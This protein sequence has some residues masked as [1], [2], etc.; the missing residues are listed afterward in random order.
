M[1]PGMTGSYRLGHRAKDGSFAP[2]TNVTCKIEKMAAT[3]SPLGVF[4]TIPVNCRADGKTPM[5]W[6]SFYAVKLG[7]MVRQES[8]SG[9]RDLIAIRPVTA[10]WPSAARAGLDWALT[11]ALD[12]QGSTAPVLWSSTAVAPRF[13]IRAYAALAPHDA[14]LPGGDATSSCRRFDLV[15]TGDAAHPY[16][17]IACRNAKGGWSLPGGGIAIATPA[18]G[19]EQKSASAL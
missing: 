13:E 12:T 16:P 17:G 9:N 5:Q 15:Q 18:N 14:G 8:A 7:Q 19:F 4:D 2:V 3:T 1:R 6:R 11:H 10:N